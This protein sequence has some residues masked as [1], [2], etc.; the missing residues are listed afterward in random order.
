MYGFAP[1][2]AGMTCGATHPWVGQ[3]PLR[4]AGPRR[5]PTLHSVDP[6]LRPRPG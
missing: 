3:S 2:Q 6:V 4:L 1:S 5:L